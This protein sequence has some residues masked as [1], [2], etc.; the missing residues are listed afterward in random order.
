M[1]KQ[2]RPPHRVRL[3]VPADDAVTLEW[4]E[5]QAS[6]SASLR[7]LI[8]EVMQEHGAIDALSRP[9]PGAG[10]RGGGYGA[11]ATSQSNAGAGSEAT[12]REE[13]GERSREQERA[14]QA[15]AQRAEPAQPSARPEVGTSENSGSAEV[16]PADDD[17]AD[18][19]AAQQPGDGIS[20]VN[21]FLRSSR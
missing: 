9:L 20:S 4:L 15:E 11:S 21:E 10:A 14:P 17:K 3:T 6:V 1:S 12:H 8:R 7:M 16:V 5:A 2:S 13:S 19:G 18:E